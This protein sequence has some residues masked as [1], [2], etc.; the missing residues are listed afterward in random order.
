MKR[1]VILSILL[2]AGLASA[3]AP[4]K[5]FDIRNGNGIVDAGVAQPQATYIAFRDATAKQVVIDALCDQGNY[6]ALDPATRPSKQA[7]ANR[8]IQFWLRDK[9]RASREQAEQKKLVAPDTSDL[10]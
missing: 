8:E 7:F 2:S 10:P 5:L 4:T 3:Q 6:D 9:V 1:L